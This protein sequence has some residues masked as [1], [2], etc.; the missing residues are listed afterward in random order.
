M[1][2]YQRRD[3]E[4]KHQSK[5]DQSCRV[6]EWVKDMATRCRNSNIQN[7]TLDVTEH[8]TNQESKHVQDHV[9]PLWL[10]DMEN[11]CKHAVRQP[12][13]QPIPQSA[14]SPAQPKPVEPW[15]QET[16][17][18]AQAYIQIPVPPAPPKPKREPEPMPDWLVEM[19]ERVTQKG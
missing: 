9:P 15:L 18:R 7:H 12:N 11:R 16:L 3:L 5:H 10:T 14:P 4:T 2:N 17:E 13:P 6:P 19:R 8:E 1:N